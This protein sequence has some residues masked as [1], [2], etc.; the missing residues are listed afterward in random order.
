MSSSPTAIRDDSEPGLTLFPAEW[1]ASACQQQEESGSG[2]AAIPKLLKSFFS[3]G[4]GSSESGTAG[5]A[6]Q[7]GS[8]S[9]RGTINSGAASSSR[10][11]SK[12][13]QSPG[14]QLHA[15][16]EGPRRTSDASHAAVPFP[17]TGHTS[18]SE[19]ENSVENIPHRP[20]RPTRLSVMG[21]TGPKVGLSA[22]HATSI[23]NDLSASVG[24]YA[25]NDRS[26]GDSDSIAPD[27]LHDSF[28]F[29]RG[30][31]PHRQHLNSVPGFPLPK[32]L[33]DDSQSVISAG[34]GSARRLVPPLPRT[35]RHSDAIKNITS[36]IR[37]M[38]GEGINQTYWMPDESTKQCCDCQSTF[39]AFRRKH[40][41]KSNL[42][43]LR[44]Q[45]D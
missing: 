43:K 11:S 41:C 8:S 4:S 24:S 27:E 26:Y 20:V 30:E 12:H 22:S 21:R 18:G 9:I 40:H 6:S 1:T 10:S 28:G 42:P 15:P 44:F 32:A 35:A 34:G 25:A 37:E 14:H 17:T 33:L 19:G 2:L 45:A 23:R 31:A 36:V 13:R 16:L 39:S 38:R 3:A 5:H 29:Y 7:Q